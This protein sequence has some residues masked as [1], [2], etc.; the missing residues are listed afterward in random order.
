MMTGNILIKKN[1]IPEVRCFVSD[2]GTNTSLILSIRLKCVDLRAKKKRAEFGSVLRA[3]GVKIVIYLSED[4]T[5]DFLR[6]A[7]VIISF[8]FKNSPAVGAFTFSRGYCYMPF[9]FTFSLQLCIL[10][11]KCFWPLKVITDLL[12][13]KIF[14]LYYI[15]FIEKYFLFDNVSLQILNLASYRPES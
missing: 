7:C 2:I 1:I 9:A 14:T 8:L 10:K 6:R 13:I 5:T 11:F 15:S 12:L 4:K 3:I